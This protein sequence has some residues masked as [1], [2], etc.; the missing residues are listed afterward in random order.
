MMH[1]FESSTFSPFSFLPFFFFSFTASNIIFSPDLSDDFD[2]RMLQ[3]KM[4]FG[5]YQLVRRSEQYFLL[6]FRDHLQVLVCS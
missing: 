2:R 5:V 1:T 6:S 3:K 4:N